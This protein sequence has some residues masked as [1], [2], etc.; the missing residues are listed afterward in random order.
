MG[1]MRWCWLLAVAAAVA[2]EHERHLDVS[3]SAPVGT[4]IGFI[5]DGSKDSGPPYL[6]VPVPGSAVDTD[7][8]TDQNT[9][10]IKTRVPLDRETRSSYTL[11]AIP[12]SGDNIR[13]V[14][15]VV[16]ENDNSPT[17]PSRV[18][19]VDFPEN[20]PRDVKR[21]LSPA[22][23][24]DLGPYNTQRYA[25]VS[26]NVNNAFRLSFHREKDGVLYLD[27]QIN[28]YLDRET[29]PAY[30]L[31]IEAYDGG[32]PPHKGSMTVN[33]TILDVN[34][35]QPMFNQSRYYSAVLENA[36][37]S[38]SILQVF[39]ADVDDGENG[40]V[41]YSINRRQSDKEGYFAID[42]RTGVISLN[43][44]LDYESKEVH[45]LVV[46]AKDRADQPLE[47][48]AF[49]T[50]RVT[51]VND[52]QPDINV[53]FLSDDA[54]PKIS[55]RAQPGEFV[56]R[57]SVDDPDSKEEYSNA[58]VT[59]HGGD[60]H[61][62]LT[63]QDK[64]IYL[65][66]VALPLDRETRSNYTLNLVAADTGSPP[67]HASKTFN[68]LVT[69][70]NDNRP[71]FANAE[72]WA[73]VSES[74]EPGTSVLRVVAV[75]KDEGDNARLAYKMREPTPQWF[76]I[77]STTG[78]ITT[79]AHMD[80]ERDAEPT[81]AV[82]AVDNGRPQ[83][84]GT[85]T[86]HVTVH[87][88]NDNEPIF[89]QS[90]YNVEVSEDRTPGS[91]VLKVSASDPDCGVNS[92]VNFTLS[93][94]SGPFFIKSATGDICLTGP[95]DFETRKLY[96]FPV[97]ATD[98]GGLSTSAVVKIDVLDINDNWPVFSPAEYNVSIVWSPNN[99]GPIVAVRARDLDSGSYGVVSYNLISAKGPNNE[100]SESSFRLDG[101]TGEIWAAQL[102]AGVYQL[103]IAAKDGS[104][105]EAAQ[106]GR[107]RISVLAVDES[108]PYAV[109]VRS[110]YSFAVLEDTAIGTTVGTVA[111]SHQQSDL[112]DSESVRYAIHSEEA[113]EYFSI[114][115][116]KGVIKT[117]A[118]LDHESFKT[119]LLD[120]KAYSETSK[121]YGAHTQVNV[122]VEDVN[123]N[124]P[125]FDS[126]SV[127]IAIPEN[128]AIGSAI[129][130][131]H[132][133][134]PDSGANGKVHYEIV[135]S[136][137]EPSYFTVDYNRGTISLIH[138]LDYEVVHRLTVTVVARDSGVP[139]L[140]D[141][142]TLLI[143]VQDINDNPPV[144]ERQHYAATILESLPVNSQI[145]QVTALDG[146][147]GNNARISYKVSSGDGETLDIH[148]NTGWVYVKAPLDRET[149]DTYELTVVATDNGSPSALAAT[150]IVVIT[151]AD[152]NDNDPEFDRDHYEF[153]VE[154]NR[155]IA[156]VFGTVFATDRDASDNALIRYS[157]LP[158]NSSFNI[159]LYSGEL[160]TK[161]PLDRESRALH[162]IIVEAKDQDGGVRAR[163]KRVKVKVAV[164]DVND[165]APV[166]ID[167]QQ[168]VVAVRE[169]Q[170]PGVEVVTIKAT[171]PDQGSNATITYSI[172]KG[173]DSDGNG[174][175][176]IDR[177]SGIIRTKV[178]L[179]HEEKSMYRLS[180]AAT[181]NGYPPKQ[182]IRMLRVEVLDLND[183]RPTFTSSSL[184]FQVKE[185]SVIGSTAGRIACS[186]GVGAASAGRGQVKYTLRHSDV[187]QHVF[188]LDRSTGALI[189]AGRVDREIKS[190]YEMEVNALDTGT[191]TN[192]QSSSVSVRVEI[193][194]VNDNAPKWPADPITLTI[195]EDSVVG[196]IVY[197]FT[198]TDAD[199]EANSEIRYS[200]TQQWP[201]EVFSLDPFTGM[202]TLMD[203]LDFESISEYILV[204]R[205]TDQALNVSERLYTDLT[206]RIIV[207][208]I[209]DNSPNIV[210]PMF[211]KLYV[212]S[213]TRPG[214]QLCRVIAVD[215][216]SK[217][218]GQLIYTISS[219]NE[220]GVF[221][222][223]YNSG[224]LVL[225]RSPDYMDHTL[226]IS[227]ADRG[228]PARYSYLVLD[229]SF[230]S[231]SDQTIQFAHKYYNAN[232]S[233][234]API[235]NFVAKVSASSTNNK[236]LYSIPEGIAENCFQIDED[237]G[238]VTLKNHLD[239]EQKSHY[240]FPIYATDKVKMVTDVVTLEVGVLDVN[241][242]IPKFKH[243]SCL[244][245]MVP[246][247]HEPAIIHTVAA[248][249]PDMG[250]NS[251]I[252]YSI[253]GGNGANKFHL[254]SKTGE[255]T[256]KTL[257]REVQSKYQLTITAQNH[258]STSMGY[259][260]ITILV[261]DEN[262][263]NPSFEQNKYES[264]VLEDSPVGTKILSVKA[265][266][267]DMGIN[268]K[269]M[270]SLS[271]QTE[272]IFQIDNRTGV[273]YTVGHLDREKQSNYW[274]QVVAKD[275][276][277]YNIRSSSALIYVKVLDVND[278]L[279]IFSK[280][281]FTSEVPSHFQPGM[282][283]LRVTATDKDEG[284]NAD[285]IYSFKDNEGYNKFRM[286]PNTGVVTA[287]S[288]LA[289]ENGNV[290]HL[291]V[292]ATD[293][294]NPPKSSIG[295]VEI[296]IGE[297]F[298]R[299]PVMRFK[300]STY[301]VTIPENMDTDKKILEIS[302]YRSDG[303]KQK[304]IYKL[305]PVN[306]E[307]NIFL[308][309]EETGIIRVGKSELLDYESCK[310]GIHLVAIALTDSPASMFMW[311]YTDI[312][313]HLSDINDNSPI[314]TQKEYIASVSEG[315]SK[316]TFVIKV[317]AIDLDESQNSKLSYHLVDGNHDNAFVIDPT[318]SGIVKTNIVLDSEIR[319]FYKLTVIATDEGTVQM[320]G[321]ATIHVTVIDINDNRPSFPPQSTISIK[322]NLEVGSTV[323]TVIANDVDSHPT[324]IYSWANT[325][326][327]AD[328]KM[329]ALD[330]YN[331][332][333]LLISN[334]DYEKTQ[335]YHLGIVVS[336]SVHT[337]QT[338]LTIEVIDDNDNTPV[339]DRSH[340]TFTLMENTH[341]ESSMQVHATD[342]DSGLNSQVRY[343]FVNDLNGFRIDQETGI[344]TSDRLMFDQSLTKMG[345][346]N[347]L[348]TATDQGTPQKST[349]VAVLIKINNEINSN[350]IKFVQNEYRISVRENI[351]LGQ[352][353]LKLLNSHSV[354]Y[355]FQF[356]IVDG[357][358][359][360]NFDLISPTGE[361]I[362]KKPLDR[363]TQD[364]Y[365]LRITDTL[366]STY[367][368]VHVL[369]DDSN[370]N[371]PQFISS[372]QTVSLAENLPIGHSFFHLTTKDLDTPPYSEVH[373][374]ITSGNSREFFSIDRNTGEISIKSILD[375]DL[376]M[377]EYNLVI[378]A[379]DGGKSQTDYPLF[380]LTV[381][382]V[383]LEDINDNVPKFPV[384][385]YLEFVGEN[386]PIGALVFTAK[387]TDADRGNFGHLNYSIAS[388]ATYSGAEDSWK[389]FKI[390]SFS[391]LVTTNA[392][393][394]YESKSRYTFTIIASDTGG[395]TTKVKV[396]I[397][398]EGKDEFAPQFIERT[399]KF[400]INSFNLPI[401][402]IIGHISATDRDK[403][404]EGRV[405]Y[406]L[407][408]Q[409]PYFKVN[410]TNGAIVVKKK[411]D[412]NF[413]ATQDVSLVVTA[414][415]GKQGSL[416]NISVVEISFDPL[417]Q[418][419]LNLAS[420]SD[421]QNSL[422]SSIV[423]W[424]IGI[425]TIT[426]LV[427]LLFG[428]IMFYMHLKNKQHRSI[429]KPEFNGHQR[430]N[431]TY[432]DPSAFDTIPI[433]GVNSTQVNQFAPP[434]YDEIPTYRNNSSTNSGAATTSDL[435]ESEKSGSSGRG[436]AEDDV[437][438]EEIRMINE[439]QN[440]DNLSEVTARNT[441][442][443][444]ARLGIVDTQVIPPHLP[445]ENR[446]S[447]R[448]Q[449]MENIEMYDEDETTNGDITN[450]IYAKLSDVGSE[451]GGGGE[452]DSKSAVY[453]TSKVP[454]PQ[455]SMVGSLSSIVHSEEELTGSYNWDY[456]LDW[457]PQYQ[458]LAHVFN[459]IA[460]LKEDTNSVKSSSSVASN[461]KSKKNIP[462]QIAKNINTPPPPPPPLLT[463]MAPRV[464]S[465]R[466]STSSHH[467]HQTPILLVPRSPISHETNPGYSQSVAM[468]PS[469]SPSLSPLANQSPSMS[470][471]HS[472]VP[473]PNPRQRHQTNET[474][475]RI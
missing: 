219:G 269:I 185:D 235:D 13:V 12:L 355:S 233:E 351:Q 72:Y 105:N 327:V 144:F 451:R 257:D 440:S 401:E 319:N 383:K 225:A 434:K 192:P 352:P 177:I 83:L 84:T 282:D 202:L 332:R 24:L 93:D 443:Y 421:S 444:L 349:I 67:L 204:I 22:R 170:P 110:Q 460:R 135:T 124:P 78:L 150:V 58:N 277:K 76:Q 3:E 356:N 439:R 100:N 108:K 208:D 230:T 295:L 260:N 142:M 109:F 291:E 430:T 151:V 258:G 25:I 46:V 297:Q 390:D 274:L 345:Y 363:E 242:H 249:D 5:G 433:R 272:Y 28:G 122:I 236:I 294:G 424:I 20:T 62:G 161:E 469:F 376:D 82:L 466:Q 103:L 49:V 360:G 44:P 400:M 378:K 446:L 300:N 278:N 187:S 34:D 266:D 180:V 239:R 408:T 429:N 238:I 248:V 26:G 91:C 468:S 159:N 307:N 54:T 184:V 172:L 209:N 48:T 217:D 364:I 31:V 163:S 223:G 416:T 318:D 186:E 428:G 404:P 131:A 121:H 61:F 191:S 454:A 216:D 52:N 420:S 341:G 372:Q 388:L 407:T 288:S 112:E 80:C 16:D 117:T 311:G 324:L 426:L 145:V 60:G 6:I 338:E 68:L 15:R 339:F 97:I 69:D 107:V 348:V 148:P 473:H 423:D 120:V 119:V 227:V 438:D 43:R 455:P 293:K 381:L 87:D 347:L 467:H 101:T 287:S 32:V 340:Y 241:D 189:I 126:S 463:N 37:V 167:P 405:I 406:H 212:D 169:Q 35:N 273:I 10:E 30:E 394:D 140:S 40:V 111:V 86:V 39:A 134:D 168:D 106:V 98:R 268:A 154:E 305:A 301:H 410:R 178:S 432:V 462:N 165:N 314:F 412:S 472:V 326:N 17:F 441:Q 320:T 358:E 174:E 296:K 113:D 125:K 346:T 171:D 292:V 74:V 436:S 283:I 419:G 128:V 244:S 309:D 94:N 115:P 231:N 427:L 337:A 336:D 417:T 45:E 181:D 315:N 411:I 459:E 435:S 317:S 470:P 369:V 344:I 261:E 137:Q 41:E 456:L 198:A 431:N 395:K 331:G 213:S 203:Q 164:T 247:N 316:G 389:M 205:A 222:I 136:T 397:E 285:I 298:D 183:N 96:E 182:T 195:P 2:G 158:A 392:I 385:E 357:D 240:T 129:Y 367:V 384:S 173:R 387:A 403:G 102:K 133:S 289:L 263:N 21:T 353:F 104:G 79:R 323:T 157:L 402:Y 361:L 70:V 359:D 325:V 321:I 382:K 19:Q 306:N 312:W 77:D 59:L 379:Q 190:I 23:D 226:N 448:R 228:T 465:S 370:D 393:F 442:E 271:N 275:G 51:D 175:F 251:Q 414:S 398:I 89:D 90:F 116:V 156:T 199:T 95:L 141:N 38:T 176:F 162:E 391:G 29:T 114:D 85:T 279:P 88:L 65:V 194:D 415:S 36:T 262:D 374:E 245:L 280:Y 267:V 188:D 210:S 350:F 409:N 475:L 386:E 322:E 146:D 413:D 179:D 201:V 155:P 464:L 452:E 276:G 252:I 256:A 221:N 207:Q 218:N 377:T 281:P 206:A 265:Y 373:F 147:S 284:S 422:S 14:V 143:D 308:I 371:A 18:M 365:S 139:S 396:K 399:F 130:T 71:E 92:M 81:F 215:Y 449:P 447:S 375:Y 474:E 445:K 197:N 9:G 368:Y 380:S 200:I 229:V 160:S 33:V 329:F 418:P 196:S 75:D 53:I 138:G 330:R 270:Y 259:C 328:R 471:L 303:R 458:P 1:I 290:F 255:L 453:S 264:V 56:A 99:L 11:V 66:V 234:D 127:R 224:V 149:R 214:N 8:I 42:K 457:G 461:S 246:E 243:E 4:R 299:I 304:V 50:V 437:E 166:I 343:A 302:A 132:A 123:D 193:L 254:D 211:K 366:N 73:S 27:L 55:E 63:T 237:L 334:L 313:I 7:L 425:L 47:T 450:M 362:V 220:K 57:I 310:S 118:A 232:I 253:T 335:T 354:D 286:N 153:H 64:I 152:V 250:T 342:L 333:I